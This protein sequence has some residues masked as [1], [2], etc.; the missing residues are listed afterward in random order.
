MPISAILI[1]D[2]GVIPTVWYFGVVPTVWYFGVVPTVWY[3]G[4]VPTVWYFF[5]FHFIYV[6]SIH[7]VPSHIPFLIFNNFPVTKY[8]YYSF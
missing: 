3:F 7:R 8:G 4:V 1:F 2:F 6:I 5:V